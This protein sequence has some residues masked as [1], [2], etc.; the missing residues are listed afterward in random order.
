MAAHSATLPAPLP[1]PLPAPFT[2]DRF[3]WLAYGMLAFFAYLQAAWG[4]TIPFLREELGLSYTVA[5]FHTSALALGM[6]VAGALGDRLAR[7]LGRRLL[8]WGGGLGMALGGALLTVAATHAAFTIASAAAMGLLGG[9][10]LVMVQATLADRHGD[11]RAIALTESNVVASLGATCAPLL[12]GGFASLSVGEWLGWRAGFLIALPVW[13]VIFWLLRPTTFPP[14]PRFEEDEQRLPA[15]GQDHPAGRATLPPIF[16]LVWLV[17]VCAVAMEWCVAFWGAEFLSAATA[18]STVQA[19]GAMTLFF[20]SSFVG[21][22]G[23]SALA[24]RC[25]GLTLLLG[26]LGL[27]ALGLP[28]F[29]LVPSTAATLVGLSVM[30][31]GIANLFPLALAAATDVAPRLA[32]VASARV[33]LGAGTAIFLAPQLL[34]TLA[35]GVGIERAF[36]VVAALLIAALAATLVA[37]RRLG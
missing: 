16:W 30:G 27:V 1:S 32:D 9:L 18:L 12:I 19:S 4:P 33:S 2:R 26:A 17:V 8:F 22:V 25:G 24:R 10:L 31:L 35:D 29:W 34:G 21:R 23:G 36:G 37:R 5:G 11:R 13:G 28:L 6:M 3:T 20:A 14:A 7:Q 15:S